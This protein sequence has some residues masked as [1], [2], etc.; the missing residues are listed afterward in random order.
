MI[1][2]A[3][4]NQPIQ[5][6]GLRV[7]RVGRRLATILIAVALVVICRNLILDVVTTILN[8]ILWLMWNI[9][10]LIDKILFGVNPQ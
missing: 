6:K 2:A 3:I 9:A 1:R 10:G 7:P 5:I 8:D 4:L